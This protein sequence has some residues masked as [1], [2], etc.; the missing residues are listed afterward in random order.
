MVM[1]HLATA[2]VPYQRCRGNAKA[3]LCVFLLA[4]VGLDF[5]MLA[6]VAAGIETITPPAFV[7]TSF[8]SARTAM[9][10]SHDLVPV[11]GWALA[12][13]MA[14]YALKR[15]RV[16]SA[17]C[18]AL[19]LLHDACDLVVGFEH[20]LWNA[21]SPA[22]G[23]KLYTSAPVAGL[24][25]ETVLCAGVVWWFARQRAL[26]GH[27]LSRRAHISLYALLVGGTL[28]CLPIANQSLA[29]LLKL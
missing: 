26:C 22:I 2:F 23:L 16:V 1:G 7:D 18:F 25:I 15:D 13:A 9:D 6:L 28:A 17:W 12:F 27:T 19:V 20:K 3:T 14:V 11:L 10:Y 8:S 29:T 24:L 21:D 4:A 5:L